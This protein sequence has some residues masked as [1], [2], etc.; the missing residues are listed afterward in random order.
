MKTRQII[1]VTLVAVMAAGM[2]TTGSAQA[3]QTKVP[4]SITTPDRVETKIGTLQF[5]DGYPIG[6]TSAKIRDELD[7]LHG[8]E[9]F[10]N[11]IQGVSVY[12]MRKGLMDIGGKDN[13]FVI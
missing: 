8:V 13:E 12:A 4:A 6:D 7:Y 3:Q 2:V 11:L 10:M 1:T 5:K 9:A